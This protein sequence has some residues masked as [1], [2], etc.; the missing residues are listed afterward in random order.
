MQQV[1]QYFQRRSTASPAAAAPVPACD[2]QLRIVNFSFVDE[3]AVDSN[4]VPFSAPNTVGRTEACVSSTQ[5]SAVGRAQGQGKNLV[6]LQEE[7]CQKQ[8][9]R[10]RTHV[11]FQDA[12]PAPR[13]RNHKIQATALLD[14]SELIKNRTNTASY[15]KQMVR[16]ATNKLLNQKVAQQL[17]QR[18]SRDELL[19]KVR[20]ACQKVSSD[21]LVSAPRFHG[22]TM[23]P[24]RQR[25]QIKIG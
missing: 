25:I 22:Y 21:A 3:P 15:Q 19:D 18:S 11:L 5:L 7:L 23:S 20:D 16:P 17:N 12:Q 8:A 9:R 6:Y 4:V 24:S 2:S 13:Y 14:A 10:Q 1:F